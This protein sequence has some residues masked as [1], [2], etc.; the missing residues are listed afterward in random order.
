MKLSNILFVIFISFLLNFCDKKENQQHL[1][2]LSGQSNMARLN[3]DI[4]FT[5]ALKKELGEHNV[6]VVK[7]ALGT[8][9]IKRWYKNWKPLHGKV[10][11]KNGNL[12]DTLMVKVHKALKIKHFNTVTFIWMQG[13]RDART[14]Q[15]N[16]YEES[17]LGLYNQLS[18]EL[19][20]KDVNFVIGRLSDFDMKNERYPDWTRVREAQVKVAN[21]QPNFDWINTDDLNDGIIRNNKEI[22]NDLHMSENGYKIMGERFAEKAVLLIKKGN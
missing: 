15:G 16:V 6:T 18:S 9:P 7:Y 8:Q 5:P 14:N 22:K 10:D 11:P 2:I 17:L 21:S 20:R 3:P 4:S 12:Y 13:E 1:F 19:G